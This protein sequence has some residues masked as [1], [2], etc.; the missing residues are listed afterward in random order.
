MDAGSVLGLLKW[1]ALLLGLGS[2]LWGLLGSKP[3]VEDD[4]GRKRLTAAGMVTLALILGAALVAATSYGFETLANRADAA[5]ALADRR[6][7]AAAQAIRDQRDWITNAETRAIRAEQRAAVAENRAAAASQQATAMALAAQ[8]QRRDL[9]LGRDVAAGAGR[10]LERTG[11][12]LGELERLI[13]PLEPLSVHVVWELGRDV[14]GVAAWGAR[15]AAEVQRRDAEGRE[16]ERLIKA[17][18]EYCRMECDFVPTL[19]LQIAPG[20]DLYPRYRREDNGGETDLFAHL[21]TARVIMAFFAGDAAQSPSLARPGEP[22]RSLNNEGDLSFLF[23]RRGP[24]VDRRDGPVI[25]YVAATGALRVSFDGEVPLDQM[26]RTGRIVS[27]PDLER[28][29]LLIQ[30]DDGPNR[31][32]GHPAIRPLQLTL[33]SPTRQYVVQAAGMRA[34]EATGRDSIFMV[35]RLAPQTR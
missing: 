28:S 4:A 1:I 26:K 30:L 22:R 6:D 13:S 24:I 31:L 9:Q 29:L 34:F 14:P 21:V 7:K 11:R 32:P 18:Q 3:T 15:A 2:A 20:D 33:S 25:E 35:N 23:V 10:N 27:Y 12:A 16:R 19:A 17:G 8:A 5:A